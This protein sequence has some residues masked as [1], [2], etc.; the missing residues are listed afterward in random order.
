MKSRAEHDTEQNL[1][2][3]PSQGAMLHIARK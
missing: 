3:M 1:S 2:I